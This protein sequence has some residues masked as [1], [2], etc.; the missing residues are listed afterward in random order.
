M[1]EWPDVCVYVCVYVVCMY[2][3]TYERGAF[4]RIPSLMPSS[5]SSSHTRETVP[6]VV[7]TDSR[8]ISIRYDMHARTCP[9]ESGSDN[10]TSKTGDLIWNL[11]SMLHV[12]TYNPWSRYICHANR[13]YICMYVHVLST[14]DPHTYIYTYIHIINRTATRARGGRVYFANSDSSKVKNHIRIRVS[15]RPLPACTA[16]Q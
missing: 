1:S 8:D 12:C 5:F 16:M 13:T 2:V 7:G 4:P 6:C 10:R 11:G 9:G 3:C 15:P 14:V